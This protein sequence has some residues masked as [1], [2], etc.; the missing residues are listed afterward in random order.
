MRRGALSGLQQLDQVEIIP[1]MT[2]RKDNPVATSTD[3]DLAMPTYIAMLRGINVSGKNTIKM[4]SLRSSFATLGFNNIKTY[5]QSGNIVFEASNDS[6]AS[7][8]KRIEQKI[9][10]DFGFFSSC[11]SEDIERSGANRQVQ[12]ISEESCD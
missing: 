5:V 7:L 11:I 2:K 4:E 1:S 8:S 3:R 12:P 10:H 9:L 6:T